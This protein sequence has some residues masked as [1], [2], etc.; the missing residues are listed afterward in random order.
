M[1]FWFHIPFWLIE[2]EHKQNPMNLATKGSS[3][4]VLLYW[5][6]LLSLCLQ[7]PNSH[8]SKPRS[9]NSHVLC[10]NSTL[11]S[12]YWPLYCS[13]RSMSDGVF[14]LN[15]SLH[16]ATN[17]VLTFLNTTNNKDMTKMEL[18]VSHG[19]S[20]LRAAGSWCAEYKSKKGEKAIW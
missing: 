10:N 11:Q 18:N 9:P 5:M 4:P 17:E 1:G 14:S 6:L 13:V 20:K 2:K 3:P 15:A 12:H 7:L 19:K 16:I 8:K